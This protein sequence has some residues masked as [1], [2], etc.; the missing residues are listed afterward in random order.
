LHI[1]FKERVGFFLFFTVD[2]NFCF[3]GEFFL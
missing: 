3:L 2:D 1:T